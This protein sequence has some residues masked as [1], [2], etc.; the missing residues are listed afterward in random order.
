MKREMMT[1]TYEK[2]IW[3][4]R[5]G[6]F[7]NTGRSVLLMDSAKSHLGDEVEKAISD[8]NSDVHIIHGGMTPLLQFLDTHVNKPFKD[9]MKEKWEDRIENGDAEFT[10]SGNQK[11]ASYQLVA[12]WVDE[13]FKEVATD[14]L[15]LRGFREC[16]Y[17]VYS[18]DISVL[19]SRLQATLKERQV[20]MDVVEE[21]N[22]FLEEMIEAQLDE[23]TI[24]DEIESIEVPEADEQVDK[25]DGN[26]LDE[27]LEHSHDEDDNIDV[28][29]L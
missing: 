10:K 20:P 26:E 4:R 17:V 21:V 14:E 18:N 3:N 16:G 27:D 2:H 22:A 8:V 9:G 15:I 23:E 28:I 24:D 12:V 5:P 11:R 7:F 25:E 19:H 29:A 13:I 1:E 6:G